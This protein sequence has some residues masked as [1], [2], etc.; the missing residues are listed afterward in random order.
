MDELDPLQCLLELRL[1]LGE[2]GL[3]R[4]STLLQEVL[5]SHLLPIAK[6][7]PSLPRVVGVGPH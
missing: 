5:E 1:G 3:H 2:V 4:Q 7:E 6:D